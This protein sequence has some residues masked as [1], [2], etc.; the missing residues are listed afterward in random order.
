VTRKFWP[1]PTP[2]FTPS[3]VFCSHCRFLVRLLLSDVGWRL[4]D[5]LSFV[6]CN[7]SI[8]TWVAVSLLTSYIKKIAVKFLVCIAALLLCIDVFHINMT[9]GP[10]QLS[11]VRLFVCSPISLQ[12]KR[13]EIYTVREFVVCTVTKWQRVRMNKSKCVRR[14]ELVARVRGK[15][16]EPKIWFDKSFDW[17]KVLKYFKELGT[18][19]DFE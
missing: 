9:T 15:R 18:A 16:N 4:W 5:V 11:V 3:E 14:R 6:I 8:S 12:Q 10:I 17:N 7:N 1:T 13:V 2:P 19:S